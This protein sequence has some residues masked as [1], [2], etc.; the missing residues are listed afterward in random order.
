MFRA[1][2]RKAQGNGNEPPNLNDSIAGEFSIPFFHAEA[3]LQKDDFSIS[4]AK[5]GSSILTEEVMENKS[6]YIVRAALDIL[7]TKGAGSN[8]CN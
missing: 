7:Q 2:K 4:L 6:Y 8:R 3:S 1:S 5:Q